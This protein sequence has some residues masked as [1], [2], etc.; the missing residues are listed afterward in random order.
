MKE[1]MTSPDR[2]HASITPVN[3]NLSIK[4]AINES[5]QANSG[6][7]QNLNVFRAASEAII[8][9]AAS[10]T[11]FKDVINLLTTAAELE[12]FA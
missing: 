11:P 7:D 2:L 12:F 10:Q 4:T 1:S 3:C 8:G 6:F 9:F 5:S